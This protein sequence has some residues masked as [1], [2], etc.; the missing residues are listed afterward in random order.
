MKKFASNDNLLD[1]IK[2]EYLDKIP[3]NSI[4]QKNYLMNRNQTIYELDKL[5]NKEIIDNQ[6]CGA[7]DYNTVTNKRNT[8]YIKDYRC[9]KINKK[10]S[11][12]NKIYNH[13]YTDMYDKEKRSDNGR[14]IFCEQYKNKYHSKKQKAKNHKGKLTY[15]LDYKNIKCN[16]YN[17]EREY[18]EDR[19]PQKEL[20]N[21]CYSKGLKKK[22]YQV[23]ENLT[24]NKYIVENNNKKYDQ[25]SHN[26]N[27]RNC[28]KKN[29]KLEYERQFTEYDSN[30]NNLYNDKF[31]SIFNN[32]QIIEE[33][34]LKIK[35]YQI[36]NIK[37]NI[38][39]N[40]FYNSNKYTIGKNKIE[41]KRFEEEYN[42]NNMNKYKNKNNNYIDYNLNNEEENGEKNL[43]ATTNFKTFRAHEMQN[44]YFIENDKCNDI[45]K[46]NSPMEYISSYSTGSDDNNKKRKYYNQYTHNCHTDKNIIINE[47]NIIKNNKTYQ[48][49]DQNECIDF[50]SISDFHGEPNLNNNY[51]INKIANFVIFGKTKKLQEEATQNEIYYPK[52]NNK[53]FTIYSKKKLYKN[54]LIQNNLDEEINN[55]IL[56]Y[57]K[58]QI[59]IAKEKLI[60]IKGKNKSKNKISIQ[61]SFKI[62]KKM[63]QYKDQG[64]YVNKKNEYFISF[65]DEFS[66]I[67]DNQ[68]INRRRDLLM[69]IV[70]KTISRDRNLLSNNLIEWYNR[71]MKMLDLEEI[72]KR[73]RLK[74]KRN[75]AFEI[76]NKIS[77]RDKCCGNE[78]IPN[79]I[80]TNSIIEI[81]NNIKKK[82][83][84]IL[85]DIPYTFKNESL[86]KRKIN[87]I[88]CESNREYL[89]QLKINEILI[90]YISSRVSPSPDSILKKYLSI[91]YRKSQY[92][93]LLE[94]AKIISDYCKSKLN[95][96]LTIKKWK[97]LYT[98]LLLKDRKSNMKDIMQKLKLRKIKLYKLIKITRLT[99]L[100]NRKKFLRYLI[101]CWFINTNSTLTKKNQMK[102]L[103]ENMLTTYISIA[104]DIF[105][106]NKKNNPSIQYSI[107]EA[108]DS[109]RYQTKK[110]DEFSFTNNIKYIK[111]EIEKETKCGFYEK[112]INNYFS[113]VK[114]SKYR[115]EESKINF[116]KRGI[117]YGN[118]TDGGFK[119][120]LK[121]LKNKY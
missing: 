112:Y 81:I 59:K 115:M 102:I 23:L 97:K 10:K 96:I 92:I 118:K 21:N 114:Y 43:Y 101:L 30:Q 120:N 50:N 61:D 35:P 45:R 1:L 99:Q 121:Y 90:K 67:N 15:S 9:N 19:E 14:I 20:K 28:Q 88:F 69:Q 116:G 22:T 49:E 54:A 108:V 79:K 56:N 18:K 16:G 13:L 68:F 32:G 89:N 94:N 87:D 80:E 86:K 2:K 72:M 7:I 84:G 105:G 71:A 66:I 29:K 5:F 64:T 57:K 25:F 110:L 42:N 27:I 63:K 48:L 83:K 6:G 11:Y 93:P 82:D 98:K 37:C 74:I 4:N 62:N 58:N 47:P 40:D 100:F 17:I 36:K 55:Y 53:S 60:Y 65:N 34:K 103:Y 117:S 73:K 75:G 38:Q 109:N 3:I 31:N 119:R 39:L 52:I 85:A 24:P 95:Y 33:A 111:S 77:K 41:K 113:P 91:W 106:N 51:E 26:M 12:P 44:E 76:I 46:I 78:Y 104:D 70:L 107:I 8:D